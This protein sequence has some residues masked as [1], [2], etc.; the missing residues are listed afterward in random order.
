M[1]GQGPRRS[2]ILCWKRRSQPEAARP[3]NGGEK[4]AIRLVHFQNASRFHDGRLLLAFGK[5]L[6]A[7]AIDID[8]AELLTVLVIH[9][10]LP[11]AVFAPSVTVEPAG[12][13]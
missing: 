8:A 10:D 7:F 5:P 1:E 12:A 3:G 4:P 6:G 2:I 9:R 11:M 13:F